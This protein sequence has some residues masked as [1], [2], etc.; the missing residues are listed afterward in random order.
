MRNERQAARRRLRIRWQPPEDVPA[1]RSALQVRILSALAGPQVSELTDLAEITASQMTLYR[2][3][4]IIPRRKRMAK[5]AS[6]VRVR[7]PWIEEVA[8]EAFRQWA[9]TRGQD[10]PTVAATIGTHLRA[11]LAP[12]IAALRE[13]ARSRPSSSWPPTAE[14]R[15][16]AEALW[17]Q[18]EGLRVVEQRLIINRLPDFQTWEMGELLAARSARSVESDPQEALELARLAGHV[19]EK[20]PGPEGR[21]ARLSGYAEIR[22]AQALRAAGDPAAAGEALERGKRRFAEG[23]GED[24]GLLDEA[25]ALG[26]ADGA[27]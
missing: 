12:K 2:Y 23:A 19:A 7:L 26:W 21:R 22:T 13:A 1:E 5:F 8:S 15:A 20:I 16:A 18:V 11:R 10:G 24:P 6:S 3:G 14:D 27:A 4:R 9:S 17:G 25:S